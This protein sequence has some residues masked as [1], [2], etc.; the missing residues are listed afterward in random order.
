MDKKTS[1][2]GPENLNFTKPSLGRL[3]L[4]LSPWGTIF[5]KEIKVT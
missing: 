4:A 3:L 1:K 2:K 5:G